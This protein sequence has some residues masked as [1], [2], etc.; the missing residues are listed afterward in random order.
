MK[1]ILDG[2]LIILLSVLYMTIAIEGLIKNIFSI[3]SFFGI[4]GILIVLIICIKT[5]K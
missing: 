2:L 5:C 3:P 1:K 4:V